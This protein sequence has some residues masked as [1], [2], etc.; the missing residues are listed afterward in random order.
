VLK[1]SFSV[2]EK[3]PQKLKITKEIERRQRQENQLT[4]KIFH[5]GRFAEQ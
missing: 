5:C 4:F 3:M 1:Q 2:G